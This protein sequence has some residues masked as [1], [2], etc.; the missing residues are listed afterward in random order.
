MNTPKKRIYQILTVC[1]LIIIVASALTY[2]ISIFHIGGPRG[3]DSLYIQRIAVTN[4][5]IQIDGGTICSGEAYRNYKYSIK[6]EDLYIRINYVI[7]SKAY[8][9][10]SFSINI[11]DNQKIKRI[12]LDGGEEKVPIWESEKD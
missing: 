1:F 3:V 6:G 11:K 2:Y 8:Q 12:Y 5:M 4:G 9:S 10:G 7:V